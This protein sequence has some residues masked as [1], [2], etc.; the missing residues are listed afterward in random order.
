MLYESEKTWVERNLPP[1]YQELAKE[2][3]LPLPGRVGYGERPAVLVIDMAKAWTD[4]QSPMGT[5]MTDAINN[6]KQILNVARPPTH[7]IRS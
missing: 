5:D 6:I 3:H 1:E 7:A 4:P 2:K